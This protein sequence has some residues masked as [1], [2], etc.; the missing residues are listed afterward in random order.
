MGIT[1]PAV[2]LV[3][4]DWRQPAK[5]ASAFGRKGYQKKFLKFR[6]TPQTR[7]EPLEVLAACTRSGFADGGMIKKWYFSATMTL[8]ERRFSQK[9]PQGRMK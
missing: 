5:M 1:P 3:S 8:T 7:I 6:K 4:D 2:Q 9:A